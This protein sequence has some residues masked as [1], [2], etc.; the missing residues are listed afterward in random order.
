MTVYQFTAMDE[1]GKEKQGNLEAKSETA[2]GAILK[3]KGLFCTSIKEIRTPHKEL[4]ATS[5]SSRSNKHTGSMFSSFGNISLGA[6][7]IKKKDLTIMTRQLAILLKAGLPLLRALKTLEEQTKNHA[8]KKVLADTWGS[9]EG[10]HT[11]SE[12][13]ALNPKSFN[14]LYLNMVKAG[15]AAGSLDIILDRL[16][17]FMEKALRMAKKIKSAMIYPVMVFSMATLITAGLLVFIVPKFKK[18][19]SDMLENKGKSLPW[20]TEMVV[21][22]SDIFMANIFYIAGTLIIGYVLYR[23]FSSTSKG[24]WTIDWIKYNS[25]LFG[26]IVAKSS[27]ARFSRTLGTLLNSGVP[28]LQ[29]LQIVRETSGNEVVSTALKH[30]HDAVKEGEGM[31]PPL[32]AEGVFPGMVVSMIEVGE[33]TGELPDMLIMIADTYDEEVDLEVEGLTSMIEPLMIVFLAILIGTIVIAMFLPLIEIIKDM[34]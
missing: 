2:A 30:V 11:F 31:A 23:L 29:A 22:A 6:P 5:G 26:P 14:K 12:S 10:G 4:N 16:A 8:L 24:K 13:L 19:F 7:V 25:P 18:I 28:V 3:E 9:V 15:E 1:K 20:L 27:I 33:E 17:T 34:V 32:K 21:N